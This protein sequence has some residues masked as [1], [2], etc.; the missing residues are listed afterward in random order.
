MNLQM[1]Q[2]ILYL[3]YLPITF[4]HNSKYIYT[5]D[6]HTDVLTIILHRLVIVL[7]LIKIIKMI[8]LLLK[9][10]NGFFFIINIIQ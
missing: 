4:N 9:L 1:A 10:I 5:V 7:I 3:N 2:L 8:L 6:N